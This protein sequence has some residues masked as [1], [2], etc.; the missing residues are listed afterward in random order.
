M[1]SSVLQL[2]SGSRWQV[3]QPIL[4][5][6][7]KDRGASLQLWTLCVRLDKLG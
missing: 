4:Q 5:S 7:G 3:L 2:Q 6:R 1:R